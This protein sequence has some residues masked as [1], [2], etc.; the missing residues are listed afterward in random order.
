MRNLLKEYNEQLDEDSKQFEIPQKV[1]D[2]LEELE[3][4]MD[5][6]ELDIDCLTI[7]EQQDFERF[8][9]NTPELQ[10]Y[11]LPWTPWWE[12]QEGLFSLLVSEMNSSSDSQE[13]PPKLSKALAEVSQY[14]THMQK[15][16]PKTIIPFNRLSKTPPH[17]DLP[18]Q[19][20]N[21]M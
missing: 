19:L 20:L 15:R 21:L 9:M 14:R 13:K 5:D 1:Q 16:I 18:Y 17:K 6:N 11:I 2:R 7:D 10:K 8:I 12:I 3:Q 4:L